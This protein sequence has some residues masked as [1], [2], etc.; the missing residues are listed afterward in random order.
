MALS[1]VLRAGSLQV[2]IWPQAQGN[3][4]VRS[5]SVKRTYFGLGS[6]VFEVAVNVFLSTPIFLSFVNIPFIPIS[7][8]GCFAASACRKSITHHS[9]V[10][11]S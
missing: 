8:T 5:N 10:I 4:F 11:L 6:L 9:E 1:L 3:A 7:S 2:H